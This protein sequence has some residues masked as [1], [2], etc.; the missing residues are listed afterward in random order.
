MREVAEIKMLLTKM[1]TPDATPSRIPVG[2]DGASKILGKSKKTI[3]HIVHQRLIHCYKNGKKL[4]FFEGPPKD[5]LSLYYNL[6]SVSLYA[7][8]CM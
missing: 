7:V 4:Y 2:V 5:K 8:F 6:K 1:Q 3:Y